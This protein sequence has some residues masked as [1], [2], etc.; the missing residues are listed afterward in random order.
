MN[1]KIKKQNL[2]STFTKKVEKSLLAAKDVYT[3]PEFLQELSLSTDKETREAVASNPNTPT[4]VLLKLGAEFPAQLLDNPMFSLLLLENLNLVQEIPLPTLRSLLKQANVPDFILEKAVDKADVEVQQ[5]L[6][7]NIHSSKK[8][9]RKLAQSP[10]FQVA[11]SARLHINFDGEL[12]DKYK[13]KAVE[14][15]HRITSDA[16]NIF[17][18][19]SFFILAQI[20]VIPEYI[21]Q[22]WMQEEEYKD[23]CKDI[24]CLPNPHSSILEELA[25]HP[26]A[27][28]RF[29][30][31][32]NCKTPIDTLIQLEADKEQI[33]EYGLFK[34]VRSGLASNC[35]TPPD[36]LESLAQ[37]SL[38]KGQAINFLCEVVENTNTPLFALEKLT[39]NVD[40]RIVRISLDKIQERQREY[41]GQYSAEKIR[42]NPHTPHH[43]LINLA[44]KDPISVAKHPNTPL[45]ILL[46]FSKSK[47]ERIR[48]A[49]AENPNTP[50]SILEQLAGDDDIL[51]RE[52]VACNFRIPV[53]TLFKQL[54][55]DVSVSKS[56]ARKLSGKEYYGFEMEDILD[57][58]AEE[59]TSPVEIILQ[60]LI[61]D[62]EASAH[63]FLAR[64][65]D[66]PPKFLAQLAEAN[67][68]KVREAVAK[69]IN[70]PVESLVNLANDEKPI[71]RQAVAQNPNLPI[72]LLEKLARDKY[73][74]I[75]MYVAERTELSSHLLEVLAGNEAEQVRQKAMANPN[76]SKE[77]IERILCGEYATDYLKQ[78]PD[79]LSLNSDSLAKVINLYT[80]TKSHL[81]N[82]IAL[83]QPQVLPETLQEKSYSLYWFERF[84]VAENPQTSNEIINILVEDSNQLVRSAAKASLQKRQHNT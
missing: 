2:N 33:R 5:R 7:M 3:S 64:Y 69:N 74:Y 51:V 13:E 67:E 40:K 38:V 43:V 80:K 14:V 39:K 76:L 18:K 4:D 9:L 11:E 8:V 24:A 83:H 23:L 22:Y 57:I 32:K 78:N 58:L 30:V 72:S 20:C 45:E 6:V 79:F 65:L 17:N 60:R 75:P 55:R 12:I 27:K 15:I 10:D 63:L 44:E 36:I 41:L 50:V 49:V 29:Y 35:N 16:D 66:L 77:A 46:E 21:V 1:Q 82:F 61:Q 84:A 19:G 34:T 62:C 71:V 81:V 73:N 70:T 56:I 59:S 52:N 54:A 31:A 26:N 42:N 53:K 48:R 47:N 37:E 28:I 25:N 68:V